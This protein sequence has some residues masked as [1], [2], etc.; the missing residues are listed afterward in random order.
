MQNKVTLLPSM[1]SVMYNINSTP[2]GTVPIT[3][4]PP[5]GAASPGHQ[6]PSSLPTC[7][8][9]PRCSQLRESRSGT[10]WDQPR[11][12][13][14]AVSGQGRAGPDKTHCECA[15]TERGDDL[16]NETGLHPTAGSRLL[17]AWPNSP[18]TPIKTRA[19]QRLGSVTTLHLSLI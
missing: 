18:Q 2:L 3:A 6:G 19:A 17:A 12:P 11:C 15:C 10:A 8:P 7:V 5:Q 1:A 16:W 14:R 4:H 13:G 9:P